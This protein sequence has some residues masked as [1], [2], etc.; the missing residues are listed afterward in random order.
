MLLISHT[1]STLHFPPCFDLLQEPPTIHQLSA[2]ISLKTHPTNTEIQ[3]VNPV[4]S[5]HT[6]T[7]NALN[8]NFNRCFSEL[9]LWCWTSG[10][11]LNHRAAQAP[12]QARGAM[13]EHQA[14]R[15][16]ALGYRTS[17]RPRWNLLQYF[18]SLYLF[19]L[20]L[21]KQKRK[22]QQEERCDF[23]QAWDSKEATA[24]QRH[25][26]AWGLHRRDL[27]PKGI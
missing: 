14:P 12:V 9:I 4:G 10:V 3:V 26:T 13:Q 22:H 1:L 16:P 7:L 21:I 23:I 24:W 18:P 5:R 19:H 2:V 27:F 15:P 8:N 25:V 6:L 11:W 20:G 17:K